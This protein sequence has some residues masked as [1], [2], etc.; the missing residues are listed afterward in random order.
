MLKNKISASP[1]FL[2]LIVAGLL[3][4]ACGVR[5]DMQDQP[6]YKAYK[7]SESAGADYV[8]GAEFDIPVQSEA[9]EPKEKPAEKPVAKEKSAKTTK[10]PF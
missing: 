10:S 4:S 6:R 7:K 3:A 2:I 5:S 8:P 9:E 1:R